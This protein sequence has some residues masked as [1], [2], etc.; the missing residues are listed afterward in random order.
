[1]KKIVLILAVVFVFSACEIYD[2]LPE[3]LLPLEEVHFSGAVYTSTTGEHKITLTLDPPLSYLG[4][5]SYYNR[6][7]GFNINLYLLSGN[8]DVSSTRVQAT[9]QAIT[10]IDIILRN[11]ITEPLSL[12][13]KTNE[14]MYLYNY[15]MFSLS[16]YIIEAKAFILTPSVDVIP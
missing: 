12:V 13:F 9:A 6:T 14:P 8:I 2:S 16:S 15:K 7:G 1:M 10:S 5:Y 4:I 3:P 11:P